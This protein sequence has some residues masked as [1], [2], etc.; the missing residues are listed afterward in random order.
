MSE[1]SSTG[2]GESSPY[3]RLFPLFPYPNRQK[4]P[5]ILL[6]PIERRL[7]YGDETGRHKKK[8][9]REG[10]KRSL[11]KLIQTAKPLKLLGGLPERLFF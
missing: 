5:K 4:K 11:V 9:P 6:P 1:K 10:R 3:V 8:E 2:Y 7:V